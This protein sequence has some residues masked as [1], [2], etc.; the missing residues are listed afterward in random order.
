[1]KRIAFTTAATLAFAANAAYA[2]TEITWW[3]AMGGALGDTVNQIA[4]DFNASQDEYK[5]TPVFKG[6]YEETLTAG[7]AAFRAGEQ[8]N[9][10]QVFDAGAATVIGAKGAT[11]PV[12]DLLADNGVDFDINDYIAGVRYFYADSDGKMIG[13]PFNS[14]TPI[15][16]YNIQALEKAGVTAPKTWEEFQ[17]VTAPALKEAGYTA[18]SQSHLPWIFTE[19]FH[20]RHNLPFATNNNG[21]DSVDTQILVN[22]DAIK[23]HFTAVTDW[24][25]KGH[26]EWFGTGWGDNQTPFEEG[27]VAM[28]LGSSGSFG[29]LSKKNLPFD[30]SATMLPYWEGVTKEPTQTFIGGA[31]LFAMAGHD[32]EE[33]KAT[34]AFFDFLTSSEVQYFWH[35]ETGYVPITEAAYE[36]A[37]ADGHYDRAPAAEVG[38]QQLSLPGGDNTKGYRMGFY[39]QI[40]DVMNREYGRILTGETSVEDAFNAIEAEANNLLARFAKTQG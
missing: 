14:S 33:N 20:S 36:M 39:V 28:W 3:H 18:L 19:N 1:M 38:I 7:I 4:S 23:A 37:K 27:K 30:F 13:M 31:S 11:I 26:F 25:E 5:I 12:Q 32:A 24:Q 9:V 2:E 22:N 21:Y 35:K 16:Y 34:A 29:G 8:P 17:T 10:M 15:M 6:T 40:R